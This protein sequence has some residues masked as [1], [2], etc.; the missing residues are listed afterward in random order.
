[1]RNHPGDPLMQVSRGIRW[2]DGKQIRLVAVLLL[3]LA[4]LFA[5]AMSQRATTS[6]PAGFV[7]VVVGEQPAS[8]DAPERAVDRLGGD[9][10]QHLGVIDGFVASV[11]A[12]RVDDL[13]AAGIGFNDLHTTQSSLEDIFVDLVRQQ[14]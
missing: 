1:M 10:E 7:S 14:S 13:G 9:V 2:D 6:G 8:G 12:D 3:S 4:T 5:Y 11:P